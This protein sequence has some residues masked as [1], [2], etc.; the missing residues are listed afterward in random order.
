MMPL[1][2]DWAT[3][4]DGQEELM[5]SEPETNEPPAGR[6]KG[7][8][9]DGRNSATNRGLKTGTSRESPPNAPIKTGSRKKSLNVNKNIRFTF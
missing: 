5:E 1:G 3:V 7:K 4:M 6:E 2:V 8:A 9:R